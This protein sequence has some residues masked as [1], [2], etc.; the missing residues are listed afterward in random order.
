MPTIR[1]G[2]SC[3]TILSMLLGTQAMAGGAL[4]VS[5]MGN[6]GELTY[7]LVD[8]DPNDGIAPNVVFDPEGTLSI[9]VSDKTLNQS[10]EFI[11]APYSDALTGSTALSNGTAVLSS[12]RGQL[13]GSTGYDANYLSNFSTAVLAGG[14]SENHVGADAN[15]MLSFT[16]TP[17]TR[18]EFS[19]NVDLNA[20]VDITALKSYQTSLFAQTSAKVSAFVGKGLSTDV[21]SFESLI[22]HT[23]KVYKDGSVL[24]DLWSDPSQ[25]SDLFLSWT[26]ASS[27][28]AGTMMT[29]T[30]LVNSQIDASPISIPEAGTQW[31]FGLG[32]MSLA[33][34]VR[35]RR[36]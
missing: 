31:M 32:L 28:N 20:L 25:N 15:H 33:G 22:S 1:K 12:N 2:F 24:N 35:R 6:L 10:D 3:L 7:K 19:A 4:V 29:V 16:L 30:M 18:I 21:R 8:L 14:D 13:S 5:S 34:V 11:G 27:S 17:K 9:H 36:K 23:V 26:N